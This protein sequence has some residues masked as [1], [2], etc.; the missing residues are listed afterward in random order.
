MTDSN[1]KIIKITFG[2]PS[3]ENEDG[4]V[5]KVFDED[6]HNW[7]KEPAHNNLFVSSQIRYF[8]H[9]LKMRGVLS[10]NDLYSAL[11]F[12]QTHYGQ[13]FGWRNVE[14]F[15]VTFKMSD[16]TKTFSIDFGKLAPI[17]HTVED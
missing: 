12:G 4:R 15:E 7:T 3:D 16:E 6:N 10:L 13:V 14:D 5:V 8:K 9:V 11:G 1:L 17:L 2:F